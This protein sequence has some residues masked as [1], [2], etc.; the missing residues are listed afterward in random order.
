MVSPRGVQPELSS[1]PAD[2]NDLPFKTHV[3]IDGENIVIFAQKQE[4]V[5]KVLP[6]LKQYLCS[7]SEYAPLFPIMCRHQAKSND[8]LHQSRSRLAGTE[9]DGTSVR[10][11]HHQSTP[12]WSETPSS[13]SREAFHSTNRPLTD[14]RNSTLTNSIRLVTPKRTLASGG[15]PSSHDTAKSTGKTRPVNSEYRTSRANES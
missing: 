6:V 14:S 3:N 2:F 8:E 13:T 7:N 10:R 12:I 4:F 15:D 1:F 11:Q 5:T 9:N